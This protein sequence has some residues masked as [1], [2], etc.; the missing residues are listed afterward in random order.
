MGVV[1]LLVDKP[2]CDL[3]DHGKP[4]GGQMPEMTSCP[5]HLLI[6][7]TDREEGDGWR[8]FALSLLFLFIFLHTGMPLLS[9]L[10]L[11][12]LLHAHAAF[13]GSLPVSVWVGVCAAAEGVVLRP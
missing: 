5:H 4:R 11:L 1:L 9:L 12:L 13:P 8:H 2:A 10:L 3:R 7:R 6:M